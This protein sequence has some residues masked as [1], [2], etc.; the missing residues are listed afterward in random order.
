MLLI[1]NIHFLANNIDQKLCFPDLMTI[2]V[3]SQRV[4]FLADHVLMSYH[5][6]RALLSE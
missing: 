4:I 3:D 6:A 1:V 5:I 2:I